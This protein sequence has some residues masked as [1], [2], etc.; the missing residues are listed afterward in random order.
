[1]DNAAFNT[2]FSSSTCDVSW[3]LHSSYP[4]WPSNNC[5][6]KTV[7]HDSV[8]VHIRSCVPKKFLTDGVTQVAGCGLTPICKSQKTIDQGLHGV[9]L[10]GECQVKIGVMINTFQLLQHFLLLVM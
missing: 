4:S 3:C 5:V 1:M 9:A 10:I 8:Q 2:V 6:P 7:H